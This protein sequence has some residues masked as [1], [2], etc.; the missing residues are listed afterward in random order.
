MTNLPM[1]NLPMTNL[2]TTNLPK[3]GAAKSIVTVVLFL[4]LLVAGFI[5]LKEAGAQGHCQSIADTLELELSNGPSDEKV[6]EI[7]GLT[8]TKTRTPG[9]N[10]YVEEYSKGGPLK[11]YT[12]YA[13]YRTGAVKLLE[14]VSV[15][16][17]IPEW[18]KP[19]GD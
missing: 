18:E 12:T 11:N 14:A 16:Q 4:L 9:P 19:G 7:L 5:L 17:T 13:Y 6:H 2:P 8:P 3:R 1:T 10:I 15:N